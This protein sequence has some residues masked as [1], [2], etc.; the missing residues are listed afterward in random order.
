MQTATEQVRVPGDSDGRL[1]NL[2]AGKLSVK[3]L[4]LAIDWGL[5]IFM[6]PFNL[7]HLGKSVY[8]MWML[9]ASIPAYFSLLD[10]GYSAAVVRF[11]AQYRAHGD[12]QALNE[13]AST[14]FFFFAG[15]G[16]SAYVIA[17]ILA[18]N[19]G[20]L[21][22][23]TPEQAITARQ[24]LLIISVYVAVG[25]PCSVFGGIVRGSMDPYVTSLISIVT[26]LTVVIVNVVVLMAGYGIV[27]LVAA[28][29][30][31]RTLSYF[32]YWKNA[33]RVFPP[34][35]IRL[36]AFRSSRLRELTGFSIALLLIDLAS[37]LN[38]STDPLIIGT[39]MST[40]A[41]AS[42]AIAQRPAELMQRFS[43]ELNTTVF[44]VIVSSATLGQVDRLRTVFLRGT[45]LSLAV[46][47]ILTVCLILLARPLIMVWV[48]PELSESI[49][50]IYVLAFVVI[51]R[52]CFSP[53]HVL[54][55]GAG[56]HR[57]LAIS[58]VATGIINLLL[59]IF[60][61]RRYGLIGVAFGTLI[62]LSLMSSLVI[63]PAACRR[64]GSSVGRAFSV[65]ILPALWPSLPMILIV[66]FARSIFANGFSALAVQAAIAVVSYCLIFFG[67]ALNRQERGWYLRNAKRLIQR[68]RVTGAV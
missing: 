16:L 11:A 4:A 26:S 45:Q 40:A 60:L 59:S 68:P 10:L 53:A 37:K 43:G 31:V 3:Y 44:P 1:I 32:A 62:P 27:P 39:Y 5:A 57:L 64:I 66:L 41:V 63:F 65:A 33:C 15:I 24:V 23:L 7:D 67:L 34:L 17:A 13:I 38:Y 54:L 18:F 55:E 12:S 48:G 30:V 49:P 56:R 28:I 52:I 20:D 25:F 29:T 35:R 21:L 58:T 36:S 22:N 51:I 8:G 14:I 2:I 6:V 19:I 47:I 46:V 61:V 50:V 42:W 9:V